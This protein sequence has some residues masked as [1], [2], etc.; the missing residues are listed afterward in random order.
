MGLFLYNK[1]SRG[2]QLR[3]AQGARLLLISLQ[4]LNNFY[5][6]G[7]K[8]ALGNSVQSPGKRKGEDKVQRMKGLCLTRVVPFFKSS[9]GSPL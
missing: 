3:A 7:C 9:S 2:R 4:S 6:P 1:E 5:P 8:M